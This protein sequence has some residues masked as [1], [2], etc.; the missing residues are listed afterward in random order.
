MPSIHHHGLNSALLN[1]CRRVRHRTTDRIT[2]V[3]N[4]RASCSLLRPH[5][6]EAGRH[7][8]SKTAEALSAG[9]QRMYT[10]PPPNMSRMSTTQEE[11][12]HSLP[13]GPWTRHEP[14]NRHK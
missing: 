2:I 8:H 12:N 1:A 11:M 4:D 7:D 6:P 5:H 14:D 10:Y 13:T 3:T 9:R